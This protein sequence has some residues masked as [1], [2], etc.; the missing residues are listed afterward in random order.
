MLGRAHPAWQ[1][2]DVFSQPQ[3]EILDVAALAARHHTT[4]AQIRK[5]NSQDP[6][7][8]PP[9]LAL[10]GRILLWR[11]VDVQ[12][13]EASKVATARAHEAERDRAPVRR[14]RKSVAEKA[15]AK[16]AATAAGGAE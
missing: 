12:A 10:G 5:L 6:E 13:W 7:R 2:C 9:R 1:E 8:L 4:P 11:L 15:R 14:G 16:R 3:P